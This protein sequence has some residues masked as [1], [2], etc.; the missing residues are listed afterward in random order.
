MKPI[1][2]NQ[3]AL[4]RFTK[5]YKDVNEIRKGL[6]EGGAKVEGITVNTTKAVITARI[7][8]S[9]NTFVSLKH[10][11]RMHAVMTNIKY[12]IAKVSRATTDCNIDVE[13][14]SFKY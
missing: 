8:V 4:G 2:S 3:A 9:D 10:T 7:N 13:Y 12:S 14:S 6:D 5:D 1:L 11:M